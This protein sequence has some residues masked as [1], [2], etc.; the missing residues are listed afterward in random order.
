LPLNLVVRAGG[1]PSSVAAAVRRAIHAVDPSQPVEGV[2]P[3][4]EYLSDVLV[5]ERFSAVV[6]GTL[7]GLGLALAAFGLYGV[8]SY[9][10][11]QR[12]GEIGLR[13]ALGARPRDVLRLVLGE[14]GALVLAGLATGLLGAAA[15]G[16]VLAGTLVGVGPADPPTFLLV[17]LVL[18]VAALV[19][20]WLPARTATRVDPMAALRCE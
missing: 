2:A 6:M 5:S 3:M 9:S 7:G 14:G 10:V 15:V 12:R 11:G 18:G 13:M 16:R 17:A 4:T 8:M 20:C 1:E 19:A